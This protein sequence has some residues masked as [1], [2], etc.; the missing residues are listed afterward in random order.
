MQS[1]RLKPRPQKRKQV[2]Q[3][4]SR[5][6]EP[7]T[8]DDLEAKAQRLRMEPAVEPSYPGGEEFIVQ[9]GRPPIPLFGIP[10]RGEEY[11]RLIDLMES[12]IRSTVA[13]T[14]I[15]KGFRS[16]LTRRLAHLVI[17]SLHEIEAH[18]DH[19]EYISR[20]S[21]LVNSPFKALKRKAQKVRKAL[22]ELLEFASP[23]LD[24]RLGE[25]YAA[26][27]RR[28]L[29]DLD[30]LFVWPKEHWQRHKDTLAEAAPLNPF[31]DD[32]TQAQMVLL[33]QFFKVECRLSATEA[34]VRVGL[35]RNYLWSELG[36]PVIHVEPQYKGADRPKGCASVRVAVRRAEKLLGTTS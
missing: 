32:P 10:A 1:S 2:Q 7:E 20:V 25:P 9:E 16:N 11:D 15:L 3:T 12:R 17:E 27:A 26:F 4:E 18:S 5:L 23:P 21:K 8:S 29:R 34:E 24:A 30:S 31:V 6:H 36:V 35:I 14:R 33:Y 22:E 28:G 19:S 13:G